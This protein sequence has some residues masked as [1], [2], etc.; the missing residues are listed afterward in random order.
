MFHLN[1][2]GFHRSL[3][4]ISIPGKTC[5]II[6]TYWRPVLLSMHQYIRDCH[7]FVILLFIII[8]LSV[9]INAF[10]FLSNKSRNEYF[11]KRS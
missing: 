3:V 6:Q 10:W 9:M 2:T 7:S 5:E 1:I 8:N 4:V 11:G